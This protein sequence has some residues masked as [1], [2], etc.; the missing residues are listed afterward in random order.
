MSLFNS[1]LRTVDAGLENAALLADDINLAAAPIPPVASDYNEYASESYIHEAIE[2]V[3]GHVQCGLPIE[4]PPIQL[5]QSS[6]ICC[7]FCQPTDHRP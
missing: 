5:I 4:A 1:A 3:R 6:I 2:A 7:R